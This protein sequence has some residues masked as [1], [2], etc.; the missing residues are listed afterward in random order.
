MQNNVPGCSI[1]LAGIIKTAYRQE[2]QAA[3][4]LLQ[5]GLLHHSPLGA[6]QFLYPSSYPGQL[7]HQNRKEVCP[8]KNC[9]S[10]QTSTT[11]SMS[12]TWTLLDL[13]KFWL[14]PFKSYCINGDQKERSL[15]TC[16][17]TH[18]HA[19]THL[20]ALQNNSF[21]STQDDPLDPTGP[22]PA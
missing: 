6:C 9:P 11:T 13:A 21:T 2:S 10:P 15:C 5:L 18:A 19:H 22:R 8:L 1:S 14:L 20:E 4:E 7:Y 12:D 3:L 16:M 17:H